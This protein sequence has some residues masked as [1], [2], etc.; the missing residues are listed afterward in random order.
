MFGFG[1]SFDKRLKKKLHVL[2]CTISRIAE[3][4][5]R[6]SKRICRIKFLG[7]WVHEG[8]ASRSDSLQCLNQRIILLEHDRVADQKQCLQLW[9]QA[10]ALELAVEN[11]SAQA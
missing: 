3:I 7:L 9:H 10:E 6:R 4:P 11:I 2:C 1:H 8:I 5:L